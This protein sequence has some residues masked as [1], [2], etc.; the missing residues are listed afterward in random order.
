MSAHRYHYVGG[1]YLNKGVG[2]P[3][4]SQNSNLGISKFTTALYGEIAP[5]LS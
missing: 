1:Y 4:N 3:H 2:H 5:F